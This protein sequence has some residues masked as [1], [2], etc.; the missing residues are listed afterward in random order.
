MTAPS[1]P[2]GS[3]LTFAPFIS[4]T[5]RSG[6]PAYRQRRSADSAYPPDGWPA[7]HLGALDPWLSELQMASFYLSRFIAGY[8]RSR[9]GHMPGPVTTSNVAVVTGAA[10]G[11][12]RATALRLARDGYEI[13]MMDLD[14]GGLPETPAQ[15]EEAGGRGAA[16]RLPGGRVRPAQRRLGDQENRRDRRPAAG[17]RER[18]RH[19]RG[20]DRA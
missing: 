5:I 10:S 18:G 20:R 9:V 11:I 1:S 13:A 2:A 15:G 16:A 17:A 19:R 14:A 7:V 6:P 12:G 8:R 3:M 4:L